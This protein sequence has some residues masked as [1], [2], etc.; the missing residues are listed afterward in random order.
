MKDPNRVH[1]SE[2]ALFERQYDND[3]LDMRVRDADNAV[4]GMVMCGRA[5]KDRI[6]FLHNAT[7]TPHNTYRVGVDEP[8]GYVELLN[9]DDPKYG[10]SGVT[11]DAVKADDV[12]M[13]GK[14]IF[15]RGTSPT[16]G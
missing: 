7:P 10:G 5:P 8:G 3:G 6:L 9:T 2:P 15:L 1:Q 13:H 16:I 4:F 14:K 12:P 11:N